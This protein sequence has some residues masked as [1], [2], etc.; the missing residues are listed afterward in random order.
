MK[1]QVVIDQLQR[2]LCIAISMVNI[3]DFKLFKQSRLPIPKETKACIDTGYLGIDKI[4]ANVEIPKKKSKL[5]PLTKEDRIANKSKASTRIIVEHINAK[6][7]TFR[8]LGERYRNRRKQFGLR[9]NLI[10]GLINFDRG[11]M[12]ALV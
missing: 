11:F 2:I 10:C 5:H 6:I 1:A 9:F 7:K 4:H 8:I 3:H 12:K